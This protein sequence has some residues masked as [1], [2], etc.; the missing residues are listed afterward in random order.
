VR[1]SPNY[2]KLKEMQPSN[3][4][5]VEIRDRLKKRYVDR[6]AQRL[7][8][9][10][11]DLVARNW[12]ELKNDCKQ[13]RINVE[14]FGFSELRGLAEKAETAIPSLGYSKIMV[15]GETKRA[16]DQ[17]LTAI[18]KIVAGNSFKSE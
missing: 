10:R 17:L 8:K 1:V 9:M 13:I 2:G 7:R 5:P 14:S 3:T 6:L 15:S 12:D 18:D 11:K 16:L 4:D